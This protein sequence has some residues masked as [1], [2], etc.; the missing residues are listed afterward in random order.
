M[1][2]IRL[3]FDITE[4]TNAVFREYLPHGTKQRILRMLAESLSVRLQEGDPEFV[5]RL[6]TRGIEIDDLVSER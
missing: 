6:I 1:S 5:A 2:A 4:E 3:S